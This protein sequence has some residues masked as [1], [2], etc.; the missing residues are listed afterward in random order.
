MPVTV[1]SAV[2]KRGEEDKIRA[3]FETNFFR[4]GKYD[5]GRAAG[6]AG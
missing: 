5:T 4:L 6:Y 2:L 1:I 3:Q